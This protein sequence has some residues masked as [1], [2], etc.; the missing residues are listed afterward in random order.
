M[1]SRL[2]ICNS[3]QM[4]IESQDWASKCNILNF[5]DGKSQIWPNFAGIYNVLLPIQGILWNYYSPINTKFFSKCTCPYSFSV[6]PTIQTHFA[7][8]TKLQQD[9]SESSSQSIEIC[10]VA[11]SRSVRPVR[12]SRYV[13]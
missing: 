12:S 5:N 6:K 8:G 1:G 2:F 4:R 13:G 11:L 7:I 9:S 3:I 10:L